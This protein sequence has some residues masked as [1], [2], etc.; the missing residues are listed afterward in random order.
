MKNT[1][2]DEKY[3]KIAIGLLEVLCIS[4]VVMIIEVIYFGYVNWNFRVPVTY[5]GGDAFSGI[6]TMK[7][8]MYGDQNRLGWPFYE[9]VSRYSPIFNRVSLIAAS[10]INIYVDDFYVA[11]NI[12]LFLIPTINVV[13]SYFVFRNIKVSKLMAFLGALIFG[14]SPY[15]QVRLFLHQDLAAVE[16]IP[17]V[18]MMCFWLMEDERFATPCKSFFRYKRNIFLIFSGWLIA[19]NGIVYYPFFSC[20]IIL[21]TGLM[22]AIHSKTIKKIIPSVI[23]IISIVFWLGIGFIPA[24]YG[25][26]SGR[27]DVATNGTTRD[28][29]RSTC[30]GLDIRSLLLSPRGFGFESIKNSYGYL[31]LDDAEQYYSYL[32]VIGIIGFIILLLF[33]LINK[34][35]DNVVINRIVLL[36]RINIMLILLGVSCGIGVIVALFIPFIASY[37]RVSIF[38][39][40]A[41]VTS[42]LL[43]MDL[44]LHKQKSNK[45]KYI[46]LILA[47]AA[48]LLYGFWE[49]SKCYAYLDNEMLVMNSSQLVQDRTFFSKLEESAG[50]QSMVYVLPYMSSF[51]NGPSGYVSDYE[52]FREYMNTNTIR[53]SYGA[54][55]GSVNDVWNYNTSLMS[56]EDMI[57]ELRDKG[58]AGIYINVAA[59]EGNDGVEVAK[60]LL[61][62]LGIGRDSIIVHENKYMFYIPIN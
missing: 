31:I 59:Y 30:Y 41:C 32:G 34:K 40:F 3:K 62:A 53:W 60:G 16:C 19:N 56:Y 7:M 24:I 51:E 5:N 48:I 17:I 61:D 25:A 44:W 36:S 54:I 20:F 27:G 14:F 39:L 10:I 58:F 49:Q 28:A 45:K 12:F 6:A 55:A 21:I 15:V 33:L 46:G 43:L 52:H 35:D 50:E 2:N 23:C 11:Q 37:N 13:V 26:F 38:M 9:D 18:F 1:M 47:F 29:F 57:N 22:I 8:R 4:I 42:V